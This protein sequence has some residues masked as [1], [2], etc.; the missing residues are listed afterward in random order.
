MQ[1]F[2]RSIQWQLILSM[3]AALLAS[4]LIVILVYAS[5]VERLA[6]RY[7]LDEALPANINAIRNDIERTLAAPI[8]ATAGIAGNT[9]VHDWLIQGEDSRQAEAIGRYLNGVKVQQNALTTSVAVLGSG[10]YYSDAGLSRTLSRS[11]PADGWFYSLVDGTL[12][13]RVELDVDK[14]TGQPTLFINQ[15]ISAGGRVLG[16]AGLGYSLSAMSALI[17]DFRFGERGEVYLVGS[18]GQVKIHPRSEHNGRAALAELAGAQ[19]ARQ[20]ETQAGQVVRFERDGETFLA[21]AQPLEGLGWALIAEVPEAEIFGEARRTL[22]T[23]SLIGAAIGLFFLGVI[24]LLARGLVRPIRQVTAALVEIGGGGGD[25]T[26]RLDENRADELGDLA[27]GFNRFIGSLRSLIGDVLKTSEQLRSAVGQ[28]ARVVDDTAVR[29]GRQHE[30]TDMVATAVHEMGLTVQEIARNA[31]NAAQASQG[32]R[33]EALEAR[34][35]VGESIGHIERMSGEIGQAAGSVTE[36]A[37]QVASI[38]QVLAVIRSISEQTNLLALNAA[39]EAARAGDMGRGFAVVADEVRTLASRTQAS[40]DEIQQ[41]IGRLKNGAE[42]AVSAM[43]AGQAATGTGVQASQRTGQSLQAITAQ[44]EAISD[45]NTQVA[46]AT[47]E[48]SSVTEEITHNVQGIADLAQATA[49]D[50]QG[51]RADCQTLS[52]LAEDLGRQMGSFRL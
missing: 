45:M 17:A 7:L 19:A 47:E 2:K 25:L 14:A 39:I 29:A 42:T 26:R 11:T 18:D 52:K 32:A 41:M 10:H 8:T 31:S 37:Q 51:C 44:V 24:V 5:A 27:R 4:L 22:W 20:L 48:Q 35:V 33:S 43:H 23:T 9:L 12:E 3:G 38:D 36:L 1:F 6:E 28:V 46:A 16:V 40:T 13:R 30:M 49:Q 15:R 50:V 34:Q 21:M